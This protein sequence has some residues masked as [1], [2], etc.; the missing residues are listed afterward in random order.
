MSTPVHAPALVA[1]TGANGFI[2]SHLI[3]TLLADG[4]RVRGTVRNP[5]DE[6]RTAHLRALP[7]AAERLEI[8][9]GDLLVPGSFDAA[10]AGCEG[11]FHAAAA[12][13][14]VSKDAQREIID[15][16]VQ[17]T[18]NALEAAKKAGVK[19]FVHT[20]SMAAVYHW[21]APND[22]VFTEADW[23]TTSTVVTDPYGAAKVAAERVSSQWMARLPEA[24]RFDLVH[25]NPGMVFGPP[26]IKAHAKASP[27]FVRDIGS[28]TLPGLPRMMFSVVD[29]RDVAL[30]HVAA[31]QHDNP[32]ERCIL[33]KEDL[34]LPQIAARLSALFPDLRMTTRTLPKPMVLVAG[35]FIPEVNVRQVYY[36]SGR[37]LNMNHSL[38]KRAYG[39]DFRPVDETLRD[40]LAVMVEQGWAKVSR[41]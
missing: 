25:L 22:H 15:P 35:L 20:S 6:A 11:V 36:L 38:V 10:F 1:V 33:A 8:V 14:F 28:G 13:F 21:D 29:V 34:Y 4:Y 9:A 5:A 31:M 3:A 27:R 37:P 19:R 2:A 32:P 26:M 41:K 24:E 12:V 23:N 39:L 7:G 18:L 30:A 40:T 16:S 17:G